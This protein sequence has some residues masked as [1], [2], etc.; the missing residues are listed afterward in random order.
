MGTF[1]NKINCFYIFHYFW[2]FDWV[3]AQGTLRSNVGWEPISASNVGLTLKR[4]DELYVPRNLKEQKFPRILIPVH[5]GSSTLTYYLPI[6]SI[7]YVSKLVIILV[8]ELQNAF[9]LNTNFPLIFLSFFFFFF[10]CEQFQWILWSQSSGKISPMW[11][12]QILI[13]LISL[14]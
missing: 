8:N 11:C 4:E 14:E 1:I 13:G 9:W 6:A 7:V 5:Y 2:R 10:F 12:F 3:P